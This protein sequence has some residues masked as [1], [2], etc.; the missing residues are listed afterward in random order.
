MYLL[1]GNKT[2]V[3]EIREMIAKNP[4]MFKGQELKEKQFDKYLGDYIGE[5]TEASVEKTV[6]DRYWRIMSFVMEVKT[7]IE[8]CRANSVSG[9]SAGL[10]M[11]QLGAIP[12]LLNNA[13]SWTDINSNTM[14]TR[15]QRMRFN[16][17]DQYS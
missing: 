3:G 8:D 14:K 12:V 9:L 2:R 17:Q 10:Q 7:V 13:G 11:W 15:P 1:L 6:T 16:G 5:S 4:L